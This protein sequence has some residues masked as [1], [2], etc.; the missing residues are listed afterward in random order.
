MSM[1]NVHKLI[2]LHGGTLTYRNVSVDGEAVSTFAFDLELKYAVSTSDVGVQASI[3]RTLHTEVIF[4]HNLGTV[5]SGVDDVAGSDDTKQKNGISPLWKK[6]WRERTS[7]SP[8]DIVVIPVYPACLPLQMQAEKG[9]SEALS[10]D[11][12]GGNDGVVGGKEKQKASPPTKKPS[13][14]S[15][16]G[17]AGAK[18]WPKD[19]VPPVALVVDDVLANCKLCARYLEN[20][21]FECVMVDDGRKALDKVLSPS[22]AVTSRFDLILLD[23]IMPVMT[24]E[25]V[26]RTLRSSGY[27]KL[28]IG[29]TGNCLEDDLLQFQ[30]CGCD[31][32]LAKPLNV[33]RL[34][35]ILGEHNVPFLQ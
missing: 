16:Q 14:R 26:A 20:I 2:G 24:G 25:E 27:E 5:A 19:W 30:Q 32:A 31:E 21:G 35:E 23:N 7:A 22:G 4:G 1:L 29:L 10:N 28:I 17:G 9:S 11:Q 3:G 8:E 18:A 15:V 6:I 12:S 33:G 13:K 34:V